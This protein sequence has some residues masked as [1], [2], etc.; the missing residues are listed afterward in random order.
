MIPQVQ[1]YIN[2]LHRSCVDPTKSAYEILEGPYD[3]NRYLMAPLGT[4][5]IIYED[6]DTRASWAP[7]GLDVWFLGTSK[8]HYRC[9]L[10]FVPETSRYRVSG[11]A[12]L[13]PQHCIAPH[14]SPETH[15]NE[16]VAEIQATIP[17]LTHR[18]HTFS[19]LRTLAQRLNEYVTGTPPPPQLPSV[20]NPP[21]EQRVTPNN[22]PDQQR[23]IAPA[24]APTGNRALRNTKRVHP[25]TTRA[26]TPG[27]LPTIIRAPVTRPLPIFA[28][29]PVMPLTFTAQPPPIP[30]P[31][32]K[33]AR[34]SN[35]LNSAPL[36]D[37]R[38]VRFISQ[39]AINF[40]VTNDP[41]AT[42]Q[43]FIPLHLHSS[44]TA[45]DIDL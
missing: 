6:S 14:F 41:S 15:V 35:R 38:N 25:R 27:V 9:H 43:A 29:K 26:N 42:P 21:Q 19:T 23:V 11:S 32:P 3:W 33:P 28:V 24:N 22:H 2:L 34:R 37:L 16:K 40:L 30:S 8:D 20:A 36:P 45:R 44:Y 39:E 7:H 1:D 5:A 10:Y 17:T 4:K 13:F 18:A 12:K 31:L